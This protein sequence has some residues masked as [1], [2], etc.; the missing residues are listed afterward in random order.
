M[1]QKQTKQSKQLLQAQYMSGSLI[2]LG[3]N[4]KETLLQGLT[5]T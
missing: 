2:N 5:D 3:E 4:T 1:Y